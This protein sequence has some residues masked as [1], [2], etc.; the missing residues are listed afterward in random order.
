[1]ARRKVPNLSRASARSGEFDLPWHKLK[2]AEMGH[3]VSRLF[4]TFKK[5]QSARRARY[6]RNL[7]MYEGRQLGTHTAHGY[8]T[9]QGEWKNPDRL[10]ILRSMVSMA[11]ASIYAPQKPKPQF[12][13]LGATWAT[14]RKAYRLD[15]I[16]EGVINQRQDDHVNVWAFTVDAA[17]DCVL[18]GVAPI[19]VIADTEEMRIA[20]KLIP[21]P[22]IYTDPAEGRTPKNLFQ[23]EPI[24][25]GLALELWPE[26]RQAI[27]GARPYEWFG[28]AATNKPR[29]AKVIELQYAW[30]L[31]YGPKKPGRWC[32]VINSETVDEGE[33]TA[34][35]FPFVWLG[36]E[37]H[38]DGFWWSGVAD[39]VAELVQRAGE[40]D[41]RLFHRMLIASGKKIFYH[42][43]AV[44]NPDDLMLN[45]AVT[46]VALADGAAMPQESIVPP[47]SEMELSYRESEVRDAW[48]AS[49]LSQV[50]AAARREP[51]ITS[52]IAQ[53][54][55]NDTK[56]GRQLTKGQRYENLFVD[57]AHQYMWRLREL[58][59]KDPDFAVNYPGKSLLRA[60]KVTDSDLP[61]DEF[62]VTVAPSSALP[63]DPAGR[64][65]MVSQLFAGGL[66]DQEQAKNLIG[67]PDLEGELN[68]ENAESEYVDMLIDKYLDAEPGKWSALD[69]QAPEGFLMNKMYALRRFTS[70]WARARIDQS[71]LPPDE[72]A[73]AEFCIA[74]LVRYIRELVVMMAPPVERA[75]EGPQQQGIAPPMMG[76]PG[77]GPMPGAPPVGGPPMGPPGP[78]MMPAPPGAPPIAA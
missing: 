16:C 77:P 19:K 62:S 57:Y 11:V 73:A 43:G 67:W 72:Q 75:G 41:L 6:V 17:V 53:L 37:R 12:Q 4:E 69:Y 23:R 46:G 49:G 44:L 32:A 26:A 33:W 7:E 40:I 20:H 3:E 52:G 78:P 47:F 64:Q 18:Q 24:D 71:T 8:L 10:R 38:R 63:H 74:L 36:W 28:R 59:E 21:H 35:A 25:M 65:E 50:S 61:D 13:T 48:D 30:R 60:Y 54:T 14:R 2:R 29:A 22:D 27:V 76:P 55:L 45:E 39:E 1:M 9:D 5:E 58:K 51:N 68:V 56:A 70:A 31:P 34:P 15:R 66:I 42:Q